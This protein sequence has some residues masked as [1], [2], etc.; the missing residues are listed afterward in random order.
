MQL[1]IRW[2]PRSYTTPGAS[3]GG[4][5]DAACV[6]FGSGGKEFHRQG[7]IASL[8]Q[9]LLQIQ[10]LQWPFFTQ[11]YQTTSVSDIHDICVQYGLQPGDVCPSYGTS[12]EPTDHWVLLVQILTSWLT[13]SRMWQQW[14]VFLM[15]L[16][17]L[18]PQTIITVTVTAPTTTT[19]LNWMRP[20]ATICM[21]L[22]QNRGVLGRSGSG[23]MRHLSNLASCYQ[24][25]LVTPAS[26]SC[27]A[28]F[29]A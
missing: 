20:G 25:Y 22:L 7:G 9:S 21:E 2:V 14:H 27:T 24:S 18:P 6:Q 11:M 26:R 12:P 5:V 28:F 8:H 23:Q 17:I 19:E 10:L 13:A 15:T 1:T 4:L 29:V 16:L 3:T